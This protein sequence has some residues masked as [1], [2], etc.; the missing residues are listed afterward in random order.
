MSGSTI[1]SLTTSKSSK[2]WWDFF[3]LRRPLP[4]PG[5]YEDIQ[6][7]PR[8]IFLTQEIFD[9]ARF[10]INK[11]I[12]QSEKYGFSVTHSFSLGSKQEPPSY[13]FGTTYANEKLYLNGRITTDG[14]LNARYHHQF[15][16]SFSTIFM[17]QASP[18]DQE[19]SAWNVDLDYKGTDYCATFKLGLPLVLGVAYF[20][21]ITPK[22]AVGCGGTY[23][24]PMRNSRVTYGARYEGKDFIL[25]GML[26]NDND[27]DVTYTKKVNE[28]V[29]LCTEFEYNGG[30]K[31]TA[32]QVGFD[33]KLSQA[34]F[35]GTIESNGRI[36]AM[37]E[38]KINAGLKFILCAE[39]DHVKKDYNFGVGLTIQ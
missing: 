27:V 23:Q 5:K 18:S 6:K 29:A 10:E 2:S 19:P 32:A 7:E 25:A 37:L 4:N 8:S 20:Q 31:L 11:S 33:Y 15:T 38:E 9:G 22:L 13:A 39:L 24:N 12:A 16:P 14:K 36:L 35:R 34:N 1:S 17:A 3:T 21:S 30:K 28:K 26:N